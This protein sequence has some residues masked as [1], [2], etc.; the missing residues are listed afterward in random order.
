MVK[1]SEFPEMNDQIQFTILEACTDNQM[2][3]HLLGC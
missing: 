3:T 1:D 2:G